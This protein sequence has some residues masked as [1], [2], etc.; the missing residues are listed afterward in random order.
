METSMLNALKLMLIGMSTVFV[1][2]MAVVLLGNL[3][4]L[5]I[6]KIG[7]NKPVSGEGKAE[8]KVGIPPETI[9]AIVSSVE[10]VTAG[11]GKVTTIRKL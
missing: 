7:N 10:L 8:E 2:L 11:K 3:I 9:A 6:N 1:I 5:I 4:I